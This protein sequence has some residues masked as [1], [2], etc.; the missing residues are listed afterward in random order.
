MRFTAAG[1]L[2]YTSAVCRV[3]SI[4]IVWW[5][6]VFVFLSLVAYQ[7]TLC[8]MI[9]PL[10]TRRQLTQRDRLVDPDGRTEP[11]GLQRAY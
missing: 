11:R 7:E 3:C 4:T 9:H 8:A 1:T 5:Y 10:P 2:Y 6:G